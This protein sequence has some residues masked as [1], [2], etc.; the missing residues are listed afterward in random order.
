MNGF[1]VTPA[2]HRQARDQY[3]AQTYEE[4]VGQGEREVGVN[5]DVA[6]DCRKVKACGRHGARRAEQG[7]KEAVD[8]TS[9][10]QPGLA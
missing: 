2:R 10:Q 3:T 1:A 7:R 5:A 8:T 4:W 9:T 6:H